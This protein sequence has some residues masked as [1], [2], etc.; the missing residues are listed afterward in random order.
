MCENCERRTGLFGRDSQRPSEQIEKTLK[1]IAADGGR[2]RE[3]RIEEAHQIV[4]C[5]QVSDKG[6]LLSALIPQR[7]VLPGLA[8]LF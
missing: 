2:G 7:M 8:D 4:S 6:K 3:V 5:Q 1:A